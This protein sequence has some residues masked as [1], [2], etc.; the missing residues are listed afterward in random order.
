[1][2][3]A[4]ETEKDQSEADLAENAEALEQANELPKDSA[5]NPTSEDGSESSDVE[6]SPA[7]AQGGAQSESQEEDEEEDEEKGPEEG[8]E[9]CPACNKGAPAWMATFADMATLLMAFFVLILSFAQVN[10]PK[11]KEVAGS[12]KS[13]F[14]VQTVIPSIEPPTAESIILQQYERTVTDPTASNRIEEQKTDEPPNEDELS[15]NIGD[16]SAET[17]A[18][19]LLTQELREEI[20]QDLSLIHI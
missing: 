17:N 2:S 8:A 20:S 6:D 14:G 4:E 1:M 16:G 13:A 19:D 5:E 15:F 11:Y 12:M 9:D 7:D 10:V 18:I 3:S